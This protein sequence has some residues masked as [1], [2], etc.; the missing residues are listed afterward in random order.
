M[1]AWNGFIEPEISAR[2]SGQ[3]LWCTKDSINGL[4]STLEGWWGHISVYPCDRFH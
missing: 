1:V 3:Q 4:T 2:H